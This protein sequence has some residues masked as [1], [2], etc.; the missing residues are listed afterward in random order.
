ME[1]LEIG[2]RMRDWVQYE[3]KERDDERLMRYLENIKPISSALV[4]AESDV[5]YIPNHP[6]AVAMQK[7]NFAAAKTPYLP[8]QHPLENSVLKIAAVMT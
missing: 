8:S 4:F 2:L 6:N 5:L 1:E 3:G 7:A